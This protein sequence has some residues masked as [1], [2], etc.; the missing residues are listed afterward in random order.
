MS[1]YIIGDNTGG[2]YIAGE[3][4]GGKAAEDT[5]KKPTHFLTR[6]DD[7]DELGLKLLHDRGAV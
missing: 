3:G 7:A 6:D 2:K 4:E 5:L 1:T